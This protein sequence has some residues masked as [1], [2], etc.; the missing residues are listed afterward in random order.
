MECEKYMNPLIYI[1]N[2]SNKRSMSQIVT[3]RTG[4]ITKISIKTITTFSHVIGFY[5]L[6]LS[7]Y[8]TECTCYACNWTV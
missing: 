7:T 3:V 1:L 8:R 5:Q 2:T 4:L 6:Y